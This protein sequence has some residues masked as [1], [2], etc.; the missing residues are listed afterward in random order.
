MKLRA[1]GVLLICN[2]R[3]A[4]GA[5]PALYLKL[6]VAEVKERLGAVVQAR[7]ASADS[8]IANVKTWQDCATRFTW[9]FIGLFPALMRGGGFLQVNTSA[10]TRKPV[11][12][13]GKYMG[14]GRGESLQSG[15]KMA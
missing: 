3:A 2:D 12:G 5:D 9:Q 13:R 4:G 15:P 10:A 14:G 1:V 8:R 11:E 7:F 6:R